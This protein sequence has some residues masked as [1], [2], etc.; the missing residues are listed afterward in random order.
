MRLRVY[1]V[2]LEIEGLG[3][4]NQGLGFRVCWSGVVRWYQLLG[5]RV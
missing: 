2:E 5:I 4:R 1:G 3:F